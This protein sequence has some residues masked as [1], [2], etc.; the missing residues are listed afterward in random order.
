M[1]FFLF[2][3]TM[4][5]IS[6]SYNPFVIHPVEVVVPSHPWEESDPSLWMRLVTSQGEVIH[7]DSDTKKAVV[8]VPLGKTLFIVAYPLGSYEPF[9]GAVTATDTCVQLSGEDGYIVKYLVDLSKEHGE[10]L[11]L[12]EY[13]TLKKILDEKGISP[14]DLDRVA[15]VK[16]ILNNQVNDSSFKVLPRVG[17]KVSD[18]PIGRWIGERSEDRSFWFGGSEPVILTLSDGLHCFLCRERSLLLKIHVDA[19]AGT[20]FMSLHTR[21][22]W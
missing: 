11:S 7:M 3:L 21:P 13:G 6:C 18:I 8:Y 4:L 10:T 14:Y 19:K 12:V 2:V 15:L 17:V 5:C 22:F 16:D 1:C 20:S 9:G